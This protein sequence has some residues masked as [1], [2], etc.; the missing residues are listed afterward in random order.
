MQ[1]QPQ[2]WT[3]NASSLALNRVVAV[4]LASLVNLAKVVCSGLAMLGGHDRETQLSS[5]SRQVQPGFI[6]CFSDT[7]PG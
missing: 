1:L 2:A 6:F 5:L 7:V 4:E 3:T